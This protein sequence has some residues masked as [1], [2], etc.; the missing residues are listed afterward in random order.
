MLLPQSNPYVSGTTSL[1]EQFVRAGEE[2][3]H[4]TLPPQ[5]HIFLVSCLAEHMS[6]PGITHRVLALEFLDSPAR[7][8]ERGALAL[9]WAGDAGLLLAG[10]F[11]ERAFRLHVLPS[12]FSNMGQ[13]MYLGLAAQLGARSL[14]E[15][16]RFFE[17]VAKRFPLLVRVLREAHARPE[18]DWEAFRRFEAQ[19]FD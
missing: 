8:G 16:D 11:P 5:L 10:L 7:V 6:D 14:H 18:T 12:Y 4:F 13:A 15:R 3:A 19:L 9:K 17:E 1:F 2:R